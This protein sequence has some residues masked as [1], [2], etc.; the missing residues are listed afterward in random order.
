M[1]TVESAAPE[2]PRSA[3][4]RLPE[5]R[6][7][8]FTEHP[9]Q[10]TGDA[11]EY[12]RIWIV[13]LALSVVTL[14]IYSA[15]AKVRTHRYFYANTWV[16]GAPFQYLAQP[17]PILKGRL[18]A[19]SIFGSYVVSGHFSP[20]LQLALAGVV[21]LIVPWMVVRGLR[22]HAR[23]SAWRSLNFRFV[24]GYGA[25]YLRYLL[26]PLLVI[27]LSLGFAYAYVKWQ[28]RRF[29]VEGHRYGGKAFRFHATSSD[30]F[31]PYLVAIGLG[32]LWVIFVVFVM[33]SLMFAGGQAAVPP[34]KWKIYSIA[35]FEYV[36]FFLIGIYVVARITNLVYN[37]A[38]L[39]GH[40]LRSSLR[41]R[42]LI[43]LYVGNTLA[44]LLSLGMLI[45]W[46]MIR[47]AKYRA[48]QLTLLASGDLDTFVAVASAE[49]GA[50][51][52]EMDVLFDVDL[53]F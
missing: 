46:A 33:M 31:P 48:S 53:G 34:E 21:A 38:E 20:K 9:F 10:F 42:D 11:H 4:I 19:L 18:I 49:E 24:G 25:A 7:P 3:E 32:F 37:K 13:N 17:L 29:V 50:T 1:N 8:G 15:W 23:Y 40:H 16:A 30:F 35:A 36:G 44:I 12:F 52:A 26:I 5:M 27:P 6:S 47:M 39:D 41:A 43:V 45:P 14:G 51:G 28:Q 2:A 22:F